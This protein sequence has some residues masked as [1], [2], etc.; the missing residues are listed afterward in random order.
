MRKLT[1]LLVTGGAGFIGSAFIK[2][3]LEKTPD[4]TGKIIVADK[5]TYA[6]NKWFIIKMQ[7]DFPERFIFVKADICNQKKMEKILTNYHID[8]I[9]NFAAETHVD[10]SI[11]NPKKFYKT[12]LDGTMS[13]LEA[14]RNVWK[15]SLDNHPD[16]YH[17]HQISTDEVYGSLGPTGY[18]KEESPYRP[19]SPYSA[20]KAAADLLVLSYYHTYGLNCTITNSSNNYGPNQ[21]NEKFIPKIITK[22]YSGKKIPIYGDGNNIRDWIFVEDNVN[23]IWK[24]LQ[25]GRS[26]QRYNIGG[27][28][29]LR[30]LDILK[31]LCV[32]TGK[33]PNVELVK[34]RPGHDFRYAVN[35]E[36]IKR[37]LDWK[38]SIS[39]KTG[40]TL[41]VRSYKK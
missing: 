10:N 33:K 15:F 23:G 27:G 38:P 41:T 29:E 19:N 2:F 13:L 36:K 1:N 9:V 18:F 17:F 8:T 35:C 4:F 25:N 20:S 34:D 37:E 14:A 22:L 3:L 26:G 21:A 28:N 30:N 32:I 6:A 16:E 24:V 7:T 40:L 39:L 31:M 5:L 12:N 11:Q